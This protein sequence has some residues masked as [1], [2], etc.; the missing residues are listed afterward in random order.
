MVPTRF[1]WLGPL[2]VSATS[3]RGDAA[4]DMSR[5]GTIFEWVGEVKAVM[6]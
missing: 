5:G 2:L 3:G 4:R 6:C 1:R